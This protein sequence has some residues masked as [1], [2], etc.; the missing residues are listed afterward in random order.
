M[1][2]GGRL[3]G[4]ADGRVGE[5][6]GGCAE[7][8]HRGRVNYLADVKCHMKYLRCSF[9]RKASRAKRKSASRTACSE[10]FVQKVY[11]S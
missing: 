2:V 3:G 7:D 9:Q 11:I 4:R 1:W 10:C 8:S 5:R 6:T